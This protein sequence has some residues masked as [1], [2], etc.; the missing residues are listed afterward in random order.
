MA[1]EIIS[2]LKQ[3]NGQKFPI[4]DTNNIKGGFYQ[5]D[6]IVERDAIPDIRKRDGMLCFVKND[7]DKI[8][9]YQWNDGR[10]TKSKIGSA[11][12]ANNTKIADM[13]ARLDVQD[14]S[15]SQALGA[16]EKNTSDI[17]NVSDTVDAQAARLDDV[18]TTLENALFK[19]KGY[20]TTLEKLN[21][22]VPNPTI[23]SKAYVGTSEPYAIYIV[24]NGVWVDSGYTGGD[25]I[26]ANITTERIEDGAVTIGKLEPSIQSLVTNIS[27]NASFAGI[28]T[29]ATNPGTPDGPVFY[30]ASQA[31]SYSNFN[32]IEIS[33]GESVILKWNSGTWEKSAFKPMTDFNSVF[34]DDGKTITLKNEEQDQKLSELENNVS[35]LQPKDNTNDFSISDED[36]IDIVQFKNGH[37]KTKYFDSSKEASID[38]SG[39][40][41]KED[42]QKLDSIS[43]GA[44]RNNIGV[45]DNVISDLDIS[46]EQ[47]N[48]LAR[49]TEG[50]IKTKNFDSSQSSE[51]VA[52][53]DTDWNGLE[54]ADEA[55]NTV[56]RFIG[57]HIKTK[58]FN[59]ENNS[60]DSIKVCIT[61]NVYAVVGDKL[62]IYYNEIFRCANYKNYDIN[63]VCEI[64][65]H[66]PR[67][68]EVT[69]T[70]SDIGSHKLTFSIK[71]NNNKVLGSKIVNLVVS[72]AASPSSKL[73]I[74]C[75]G[76]STTQ[77]G[78]W[79]SELQRRLTSSGGKPTALNLANIS[80]VGRMEV[81]Y[82]G[83]TTHLEATGGYNFLD[84][85]IAGVMR[86]RFDVEDGLSVNMS[87][88]DTYSWNGYTFTIQEKNMSNN[89][90]TC[91]INDK[92]A[93][94]YESEG[95]TLEKVTGNGDTTIS[96]KLAR[97]VGNPFINPA[98][99]VIDM[100]YYIN[101]FCEGKVD[102]VIAD[103]LTNGVLPYWETSDDYKQH[104]DWMKTFVNL[105]K[106][107]NSSVKCLIAIPNNVSTNGG[108]GHDYKADIPYAIGNG[109]KYSNQGMHDALKE[110]IS[111]NN[112][113][114]FVEEL[115]FQSEFDSDNNFPVE[116]VPINTRS[117]IT[118]KRGING[119]HP[120]ISGYMQKADMA[121]RMFV[122]KFCK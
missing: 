2:E 56:V 58:N 14:N 86:V 80:F 23:G 45:T 53:G 42:K 43:S 76:D 50:H 67:Y 34:D 87:V 41:S 96:F 31:G 68:Y 99:G 74:L 120:N 24:E 54:I 75:V 8:Y 19:N 78:Q 93:S 79:V 12:D 104:F 32:N 60:D 6:T 89:Y 38:S 21:E 118:E 55:N 81:E 15:I 116:D 105:F 30:I 33:K 27:K 70:T 61:D 11:V 97:S 91:D 40:M 84:Y 29:P 122:N 69:P 77:G 113:S 1:V 36:N 90:F 102:I 5:V 51:V 25:E 103:L 16:I 52:L 94:I 44:E 59:S 72:S 112:L 114:A 117:T 20:F 119:F 108:L 57:G 10:W 111:E 4:V 49:F 107:V 109:K 115:D 46:D 48:V 88:G 95:G 22:A 92:T 66:F 3:K 39:L 13:N 28:A 101:T 100:P 26:V 35:E 82:A 9:T 65:H 121:Y 110:Y 62:Q 17:K 71:D 64:G 63:T 37:I 73:N 106:D 85:I 47:G 98:T 18:D 7:P 83:I